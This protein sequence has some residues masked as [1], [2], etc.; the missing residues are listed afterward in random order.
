MVYVRPPGGEKCKGQRDDVKL[1]LYGIFKMDVNSQ[2]LPQLRPLYCIEMLQA[3]SSRLPNFNGSWPEIL[4]SLSQFSLELGELDVHTADD[5][6]ASCWSTIIDRALASVTARKEAI[7]LE[8]L[9]TLRSVY[10]PGKLRTATDTSSEE[11]NPQAASPARASSS[12]FQD[13]PKRSKKTDAQNQPAE[14]DLVSL[15]EAQHMMLRP[16]LVSSGAPAQCELPGHQ[17]IM[18]I[19]AVERELYT[20]GLSQKPGSDSGYDSLMVD[21]YAS[22]GTGR[23]VKDT[24]AWRDEESRATNLTVLKLVFCFVAT[25]VVKRDFRTGHSVAQDNFW[26]MAKTLE[27]HTCLNFM[28][29]VSIHRTEMSFPLGTFF[30]VA[31]YVRGDQVCMPCD[32]FVPAWRIQKLKDATL[33]TMQVRKREVPMTFQ[34]PAFLSKPKAH[35]VTLTIYQAVPRREFVGMCDIGLS[36]LEMTEEVFDKSILEAAKKQWQSKTSKGKV[37]ALRAAMATR[38]K[39]ENDQAFAGLG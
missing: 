36:R 1:F 16:V 21:V 37:L 33:T 28:G 32:C 10:G 27:S 35:D 34:V 23:N 19:K 18:F 38:K 12:A 3:L 15:R 7:F 6:W 22:K 29:P 8:S 5:N 17:F 30:G 2:R 31:L 26:L 25:H 13:S 20:A 39:K 4:N 9:E 24:L 14:T 11:A